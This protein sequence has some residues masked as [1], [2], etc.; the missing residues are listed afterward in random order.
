MIIEIKILIAMIIEIE[1]LIA[2][3]IEIKNS[4]DGRQA[5]SAD[6]RKFLLNCEKHF[7]FKQRINLMKVKSFSGL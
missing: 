3:I 6:D 7:N 1:I 2:M 5:K 4:N